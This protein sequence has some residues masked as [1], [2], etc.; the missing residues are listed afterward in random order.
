[1]ASKVS[2]VAGESRKGNIYKALELIKDEVKAK[3]NV[4]IKPNVSAS[5]NAY[6]NTN[7]EAVEGVID[8]LN[9]HFRGLSITIGE[10]S[11][12]AYLAG[13]R[14]RRLLD[15]FG[16]YELEKKYGNVRVVDLDEWKDFSLMSVKMV[17][18]HSKVRI[19]RHDFDYVVSLSLPKTHDFVIATLGIKNMM[20]TVHRH[21][22]IHI[23]GLRGKA[24]LQGGIKMF[25]FL[26]EVIWKPLHDLGRHIVV[27]LGGYSK[28]VI[29][30]N[31]NL[32]EL[33]KLTKLDLVVLDAMTGMEGEGPLL[34]E[35][36]RLGVAVAS[37]DPL[38]ADGVG[39]RLMGLDPEG[40][41]YLWY[42]QSAGYGDYS[43][44]GLVGERIER[45]SRKFKMHSRY[46]E[47]REWQASE[48]SI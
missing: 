18:G 31:R 11:G 9:D 46:V 23:H 32:A 24:F 48:D 12:S 33:I 13:M 17:H 41:G 5:R 30:T 2:L 6:A 3:G 40:I 27:T 35:T 39:A 47:Q 36:V 43:L 37:A 44:E 7:L 8:F 14:T 16:Y 34:G 1:M 22:R 45:Y 20:A 15:R 42:L 21:D 10:S 19:M 28:S 25:P 4:F 26:P 38:K 29:L